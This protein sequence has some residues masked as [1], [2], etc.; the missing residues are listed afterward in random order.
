MINKH[1]QRLEILKKTPDKWD[2][3]NAKNIDKKTYESALD[4]INKINLND[5]S[6]YIT[7]EGAIEFA[8]FEK[9]IPEDLTIEIKGDV[10]TV[11]LDE[12]IINNLNINKVIALLNNYKEENTM[13]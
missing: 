9:P 2:G 12:T 7:Y 3:E 6:I 1:L 11:L 10:F 13:L 5:Y 8:F 4:F